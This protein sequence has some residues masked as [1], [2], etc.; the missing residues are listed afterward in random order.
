MSLV[1]RL[2]A[3][4]VVFCHLIIVQPVFAAEAP[5]MHICGADTHQTP[6]HHDMDCVHCPFCA[7]VMNA[8]L[9]PLQPPLPTPRTTFTTTH[10]TRPAA[11]APPGR[12]L[13]SAYPR[14]PPTLT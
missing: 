13:L 10:E 4:L 14:G 6:H 2:A 5:M 1:M 7:M 8:A 3:L 11:R 12:T 9:T